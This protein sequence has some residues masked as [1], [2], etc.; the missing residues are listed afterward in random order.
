[1]YFLYVAIISSWKNAWPLNWTNLNSL[2]PR[3]LCVMFGWNW[4]SG[5]GE[6]FLKL[7]IYFQFVANISL[8]QRTWP[9]IALC[10][11]WWNLKLNTYY[12][13]IISIEDVCLNVE[14]LKCLEYTDIWLVSSY[15]G[16]DT[17]Y[18][19]FIRLF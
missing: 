8:W 10:Y 11:V 2:Y 19:T 14:K 17:K 6:D 9:F 4:P 3:L 7:S 16:H 18:K 1:M 5:S 12:I 15:I 13:T